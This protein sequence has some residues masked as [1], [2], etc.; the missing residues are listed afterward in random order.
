MDVVQ[1]FF[2]VNSA[3]PR[4]PCVVVVSGDFGL[5]R[6]AADSSVIAAIRHTAQINSSSTQ[7]ST[8]LE[9]LNRSPLDRVGIVASSRANLGSREV[10]SYSPN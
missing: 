8:V 1:E 10:G 2:G 9:D 5:W 4:R 3:V 6:R 7:G